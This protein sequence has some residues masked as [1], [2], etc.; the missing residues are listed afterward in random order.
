MRILVYNLMFNKMAAVTKAAGAVG[1]ELIIIKSDDIHK[2]IESLFDSKKN[3]HPGKDSMENIKELMIFEGFSSKQMDDFLA[4]Y[5]ST[6]I[7]KVLFKAMVTPI[8]ARWSPA[9]LYEHLIDE[10]Q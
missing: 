9:Y 1:A 2:S 4:A 6:G 8:N 5:N 7:P 10:V 3:S